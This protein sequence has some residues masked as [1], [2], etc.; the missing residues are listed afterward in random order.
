MCLEEEERSVLLS[1][2]EMIKVCYSSFEKALTWC[3]HMSIN[4]NPRFKDTFFLKWWYDIISTFKTLKVK[5]IS[6]RGWEDSPVGRVVALQGWGPVCDPEPGVY[7]SQR[8]RCVFVIPVLGRQRQVQAP[9]D[10]CA[11]KLRGGHL[12][13]HLHVLVCTI[14]MCTCTHK[15]HAYTT[16]H[17]IFKNNL[18]MKFWQMLKI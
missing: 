1:R 8:W 4:S 13:C 10:S 14:H 17:P 18:I 5:K 9:W 12:G 7:Q 15:N 11:G 3:W 16:Q 2:C 6:Y